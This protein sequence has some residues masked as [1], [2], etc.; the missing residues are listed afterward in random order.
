MSIHK[1]GNVSIKLLQGSTSI[2]NTTLVQ[3]L[4]TFLH[5]FASLYL[6]VKIVLKLLQ[7][8]TSW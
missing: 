1:L 4:P 6:V 5:L 3:H 8:F 2:I 7:V